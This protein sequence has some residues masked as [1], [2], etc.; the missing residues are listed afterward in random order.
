MSVS[1]DLSQ[2]RQTLEA[3]EP[4]S[5]Q[6]FMQFLPDVYKRYEVARKYFLERTLRKP[7]EFYNPL[8]LY[9]GL[10]LKTFNNANQLIDKL[11]I[12]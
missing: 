11:C 7:S 1:T 5:T 4:G 10:K 8:T 3:I 9:R 12:Q 2:L 6:D